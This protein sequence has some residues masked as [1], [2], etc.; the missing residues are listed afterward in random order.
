MQE[1]Y[2]AATL[3][4]T[5]IHKSF[6]DTAVIHGVDLEVASGEFTVFV[7]PCGCGKSTLLRMIAGLEPV[8]GGTV[9]VGGRDAT[10]AEPSDHGSPWCS[11]HMR[12][13]RI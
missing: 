1:E 13:I 2:S 9:R 6:A 12:S 3:S 10:R 5:D 4:L 7:G 11:S 8:T